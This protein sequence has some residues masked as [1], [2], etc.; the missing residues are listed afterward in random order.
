M[1]IFIKIFQSRPKKSA[2]DK[3]EFTVFGMVQIIG[4]MISIFVFFYML[5]LS[6][7][8]AKSE[9]INQV[10]PYISKTLIPLYTATATLR[11]KKDSKK[12]DPWCFINILTGILIAMCFIFIA[13]FIPSN[14]S[15]ENLSFSMEIFGGIIAGLGLGGALKIEQP[16]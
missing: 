1:S 16:G 11:Y 15:L 6:I 10:L 8:N 14:W 5:I 9:V 2:I 4:L 12:V 3:F 13:T 7:T